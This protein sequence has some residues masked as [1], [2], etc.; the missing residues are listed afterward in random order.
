MALPFSDSEHDTTF[1]YPA[2]KSLSRVHADAM[3]NVGNVYVPTLKQFRDATL[4]G[5]GILD[6]TEGI[7]HLDN[8]YSF[9]AG[10]AKDA[11]GLLPVVSKPYEAV[12]LNDATIKQRIELGNCN[13]YCMTQYFLSNSFEWAVKE[14]GKEVCILIK[15]VEAFINLI[16]PALGAEGLRFHS[17]GECMYHAD[18][19][20]R[21]CET[22]PSPSSLSNFLLRDP[23]KTAFIKPFRYKEQR[24]LRALWYPDDP[25]ISNVSVDVPGVSD[26][27][28]RVEFSRVDKDLYFSPDGQ[29]LPLGCEI[30]YNGML[31]N[32]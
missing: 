15:N 13:I 32:C 7:L 24:E 2:F 26:L 3:L 21:V 22:D 29:A 8:H 31:P 18:E 4:H 14:E 25:A 19:G 10:L 20:R 1:I 28:M 16:N 30:H 23:I 27:L 12:V 5:G 9:Y 17:I 11:N 6:V